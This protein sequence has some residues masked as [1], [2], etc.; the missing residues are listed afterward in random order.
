M[1]STAIDVALTPPPMIVSATLCV[2]AALVELV[3]QFEAGLRELPGALYQLDEAGLGSLV[4]SLLGIVGRAENVAALA[5]ADALTRG[6]V[7]N[8]TATGAPGWVAQQAH[9]VDP[10]VVHRAGAVGRDCANPVNRVVAQSLAAGSASV[11]AAAVALREVPNVL[12]QLPC[13]DRD[14]LLLRYLSLTRFGSRA[15]KELSTL[16]IGRF[17]PEQL[18][19]DEQVQQ[20]RESVHWYDLSGGLTRFEADLSAGHAATVKHALL[21]LSAPAPQP[22]PD[23]ALT[24]GDGACSTVEQAQPMAGATAPDRDVRTPGKRRADALVRLVETAANVLDGTASRPVGEIGG[25]AKLVVTLDYDTL[26]ARLQGTGLLDVADHASAPTYLAGV[27]RTTD[28]QL[29]D[30]GTLRRLACD[31]DLIPMVLGGASQPLDVGR[32]K[33]LFTGGLRAAIIHR[34]QGCT[35]PDCD[36]PP[37][38]C[39]AHH[40]NPWW[41]GGET[42]LANAAL[43][44]ARHHTIV[45]RD[46]LSAH[47]EAEGVT[48]NRT[49]GLMP[50]TAS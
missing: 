42:S 50:N 30:A 39:D 16:I 36:R 46:L 44:C 48:W 29:L 20:Q 2:G 17:A 41:S 33:R 10:V 49:P 18:V 34:D 11:P 35:F 15:L 5:T 8:S 24:N 37:D 3:I 19:R 1:N 4:G 45:H 7:A 25:T 43:L 40:V 22:C 38:W 47:L 23:G 6:T 28:G 31:A 13:A 14:D 32:A 27:G 21:F 26:L 12:K 9:G